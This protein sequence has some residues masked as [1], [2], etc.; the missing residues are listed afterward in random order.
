[1]AAAMISRA[2][3]AYMETVPGRLNLNAAFKDV[4]RDLAKVSFGL[5]ISVALVYLMRYLVPGL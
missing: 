3:V 5:L 4:G 2:S 1:M